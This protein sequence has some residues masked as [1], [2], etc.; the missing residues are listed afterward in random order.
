[1]LLER[2]ST[3][4]TWKLFKKKFYTEYFS[5]SV[6]FAKEVESLQLVQ[7]GMFVTEYADKFKHLLCF[8]T[9]SMDESDNVENLRMV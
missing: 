2:N 5:D 1:M 4:V 9:L 3:L 6:R 7:G 8:H